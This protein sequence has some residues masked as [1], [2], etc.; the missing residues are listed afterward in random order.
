MYKFSIIILMMVCLL[1]E[2]CYADGKDHVVLR[3]WNIPVKDVRTTRDKAAR[4]VF[5]KFL[6]LHPEIDIV[7]TAGITLVGQ[8][9]MD[10]VIMA[11]AGGTAPDVLYVNFRKSTSYISQNFLY[12]LD[13]YVK[14][15]EEVLKKK[16]Y[17]DVWPIIRQKGYPDG[18]EHIYAIPYGA[19]YL[20]GLYYRKDLFKKAGLNPDRP[21]ET[22][23][24]FYEYTRLLTK[25]EDGKYGWGTYPGMPAAYTFTNFIYMAGGK[26]VVQDE[27]G[28]WR[29]VYNSQA[30]VEGLKFYHKLVRGKWSR[31]GKEYKG[32][33]TQDMDKWHNGELG[34]KFSSL[35]EDTIFLSQLN[36]ELI[37][38]AALPLGPNGSR[39]AEFNQPMFGINAGTKNKKA[40]DAAWKYIKFMASDEADRIITKT[41]VEAGEGRFMNPRYLKK[42]GYDEILKEVSK[43]WVE[44]HEKAMRYIVPEPYGKNCDMIYYELIDPVDRAWLYEGLDY[45]AVLDKAVAHTNERLI[46]E[47]PIEKMDKR[48]RIA[49]VFLIPL[50][51]VVIFFFIRLMKVMLKNVQ[52]STLVESK[53]GISRMRW[54]TLP[55]LFML[56]ALLTI[57]VW[58]YYPLVRGSVMA[59]SDYRVMGG[60]S[61]IGIDNFVRAFWEPLFWIAMKNT[62]VYVFLTIVLGFFLP[63]ILAI[64]LNEIPKGTLLYRTLYYLPAVS[65]PM[66]IL[67]LWKQFYDPSPAGLMNRMLGLVGLPPQSWLQD[68]K[69]AMV[70]VIIPG[71]WGGLGAGSIIYLAALKNVPEEL[72]EAASL[73]GATFFQK[74]L[75]VTLPRIKVLLII[76]FVG[77][78]IGAFHATERILLMT[79]GGPLYATHVIGLEIF[80]NA[81][82]YLQFGYATAIAW[83]VGS[84]L[85]GFTVY[86]LN[87]LKG[88][89]FT[90][91]K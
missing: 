57:L 75:Y 27:E 81:F 71:I 55:W 12:P 22:W 85:I 39:G 62:F 11:I 7:K 90:T 69:L 74:V 45:Q 13:E 34:M 53:T 33:V 89:R 20:M 5:E 38:I 37:G 31:D 42:F 87:I 23:D 72:Y 63:V 46:G 78:F 91:A 40:R 64:M 84:L 68:P 30:G 88:V 2:D 28:K 32:V 3:L 60:S 65:S 14:D 79:G 66:V 29:A 9:S 16:V 82:V 58:Q 24:E 49:G 76:S 52:E 18:K 50:A 8:P 54:Q 26:I 44:V 51:G 56:P 21:P 43:D 15:Y 47:I 80:Y 1:G 25:Q 4:A 41:F 83:I 77:A 36:P 17:P 35:M 59:F 73:D 19:P 70:S 6:E 10:A 86:Q 61:F 48:R 67:L